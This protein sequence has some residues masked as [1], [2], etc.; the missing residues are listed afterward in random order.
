[1]FSM[2]IL[3]GS[4]LGGEVIVI[5]MVWGLVFVGLSFSP[6]IG[7]V[8]FGEVSWDMIT[9]FLVSLS[10]CVI[11]VSM[12]LSLGVDGESW[13]IVFLGMIMSSLYMLFV[14]SSFFVFYF[15]YEVVVLLL[16][17]SVVYW[18]SNPERFVSVVYLVFYMVVFSMPMFF[19]LMIMVSLNGVSSFWLGEDVWFGFKVIVCMAMLVK[20]PVYLLH[21]WLPKVHVE[22]STGMS[23]VLA[24]VLLK[25]GAYGLF[26]FMCLWGLEVVFVEVVSSVSLV[27][28]MVCPLVCVSLGDLK[29]IVAY[30]S[31]V[32]MSLMM[33]VLVN[34]GLSFFVGVMSM[35]MFHGFVSVLMFY[36]VGLVYENTGSRSVMVNKGVVSMVGLVGVVLF[37]VLIMNMG[38]P[39][40]GNF[41]AEIQMVQYLVG[42]GA[43]GMVVS[44]IYVFLGC[45][46]NILV[47]VY[48]VV[49]EGIEDVGVSFMTVWACVVILWSVEVM[50]YVLAYL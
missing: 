18:G 39:L 4:F 2:A 45:V 28:M 24:G 34:M 36:F 10:L 7:F 20:I 3:M 21:S 33:V 6:G 50:V 22:A 23:M 47:Y 14:S 8:L 1:M 11:M 17:V 40:S 30:S 32:H 16:V 29:E 15:V 38:F 31:V 35:M 49:G 37:V 12:M 25:M 26:R 46:Y 44:G 19:V 27:G 48:M 13:L 43:L 5:L 41:I 42:L 9:L